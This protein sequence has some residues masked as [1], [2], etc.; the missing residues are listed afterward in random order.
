MTVA[1]GSTQRLSSVFGLVMIVA[2]V[3]LFAAIFIPTGAESA[4]VVGDTPSKSVNDELS[5]WL[6]AAASR[7]DSRLN[8]LVDRLVAFW[9]LP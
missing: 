8:R 1:G 5:R 6:M 4:A 2:V 3:S 7:G 9:F